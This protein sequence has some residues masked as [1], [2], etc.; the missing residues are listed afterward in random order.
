[1]GEGESSYDCYMCATNT[2]E[3]DSPLP[4]G[5][6]SN[7]SKEKKCSGQCYIATRDKKFRRGCIGSGPIRTRNDCENDKETCSMC[8]SAFCNDKDMIIEQCF[9]AKY[10]ISEP[11]PLGSPKKCQFISI[12]R[13][14]CYHEE[15]NGV[16]VK[17]CVSDLN[18]DKRKECAN[19]KDC[20]ICFNEKCNSKVVR[21]RECFH[22]DP[23]TNA[24]SDP[25]DLRNITDC[26]YSSNACLVGVDTNGNTHRLCASTETEDT[27]KFPKGFTICETDKCNNQVFPANRLKCLHCKGDS[28]CEL[29]K[30]D[31]KQKLKPKLCETYAVDEKCYTYIDEGKLIDS[32]LE[33]HNSNHYFII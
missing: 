9:E 13:L 16:A 11:K 5:C 26:S 23:S 33:A 4:N 25:S 6:M 8:E 31:S 21:H 3:N 20:E 17:G 24:C 29:D 12:N 32:Q 28:D 30:E 27:K 14:G 15:K 19:G 10:N 18:E 22:C 7:L 1:M 2:D